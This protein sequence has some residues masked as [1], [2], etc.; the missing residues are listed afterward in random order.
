MKFY[1]QF[2]P[3]VDEILYRTYFAEKR[4]GFFIE[5]GAY[6]G[7]LECSCKF[8]EES[9]GWCGMNIEAS[10]RIFERLVRNRPASLNVNVALSDRNGRSRFSDVASPDGYADGNGSLRHKPEHLADLAAHGCRLV[11]VEVATTTYCDIVAQHGVERVDLFVLDVEGCELQVLAGMLGAS[12]LPA[13]VCVEFSFSGLGEVVAAVERLGLRF[14]FVQDVNAFFYDPKKVSAGAPAIQFRMD[15]ER[16]RRVLWLHTHG[17]WR[18]FELPMLQSFGYEVFAAKQLLVAKGMRSASSDN[19]YDT[20]L[21]LIPAGVLARLNAHNFYT[22]GLPTDVADYLNTY[23]SAVFLPPIPLSISSIVPDFLRAFR[24][25]IILR[26]A[27]REAPSTY[28]DLFRSLFQDVLRVRDRFYFVPAYDE[29]AS[30]EDAVLRDLAVTLPLG[31]PKSAA[32]P[33]VPWAGGGGY[34][35]FFCPEIRSAYYGNIYREFKRAFGDLPHLIAG[36]QPEPVEGDDRVLGFMS[37]DRL[38]EIVG[39]AEVL[40]YHS[41]EP[42][43]VHYHPFEAVVAGLPVVYMKGGILERFGG[44]DQLGACDTLEEARSKM[45][46][47][48]DGDEELRRSILATQSRLLDPMRF[49]VCQ[50]MW[51]KRLPK[52][53]T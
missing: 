26:A 51:A 24:G 31:L 30:V 8:F 40:F 13:V 49:E 3:S 23:F 42:R 34:L 2:R 11:G 15:S 19:S 16:Q 20:S 39:R 10:P 47:L 48:L 43:H 9:L 37:R 25:K 17:Q 21:S 53:L 27:G 46:R 28:T 52:I 35:L 32:V 41:R 5:C 33:A 7:L 14:D 4:D 36:V 38:D 18:D 50:E 44:A 1:G 22:D 45:Q 6:D 12:V 29:I